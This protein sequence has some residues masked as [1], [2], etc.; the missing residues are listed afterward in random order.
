MALLYKLAA[1][2]L[3]GVLAGCAASPDPASYSLASEG[4][5]PTAGPATQSSAPAPAVYILNE[6]EKGIDCKRLIGRMKIRIIQIKDYHKR[7]KTSELSRGLQQA[8]SQ[9]GG[10]TTGIDPDAEYTRD[11]AMLDA[12]NAQLGAKG[13][14]QLDLA[15][16]LKS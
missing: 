14:P 16:E 2:S 7:A 5:P 1:L 12:Y 13:C 6:E 11:R 15:A 4:Q 8:Q 9:F 3:L 10:S